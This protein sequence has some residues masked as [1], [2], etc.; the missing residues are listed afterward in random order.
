M[1]MTHN[2]SDNNAVPLPEIKAK[3][4]F[5]TEEQKKFKHRLTNKALH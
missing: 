1:R 2:Q 3:P 5:Y 4:F